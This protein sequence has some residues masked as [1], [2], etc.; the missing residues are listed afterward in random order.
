M[1]KNCRKTKFSF[2]V[3][4]KSLSFLEQVI[5]AL[6]DKKRDHVPYR[7]AKLTHVLRDAL[8]GNCQTL[9]I[10]NLRCEKQHLDETIATLR[11]ATRMMCVQTTPVVNVHIDPMVISN[12]GIY[13]N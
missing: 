11:F 1:Q 8:G 4:N 3:I 13:L 6:S 7:Q 9:M 10:A 5:L 2:L 12:C